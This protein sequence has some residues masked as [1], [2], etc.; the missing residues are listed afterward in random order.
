[1]GLWNF[2]WHSSDIF[3]IRFV[4]ISIR[5]L[6]FMVKLIQNHN[7][8]KNIS[9]YF[10]KPLWEQAVAV[11]F[12]QVSVPIPRINTFLINIFF[13]C[14]KNQNF[15]KKT[16]IPYVSLIWMATFWANALHRL[17]LPVPKFNIH[18]YSSICLFNLTQNIHY[19]VDHA[20]IP[21]YCKK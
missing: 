6:I 19:L 15:W 9:T 3:Q 12:E 18:K 2:Q 10:T 8:N 13:W 5:F 1:M 16:Q 21:I 14:K 17:V 11:D 4:L 7:L 20:I